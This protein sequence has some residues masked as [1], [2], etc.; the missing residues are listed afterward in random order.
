MPKEENKM[1]LGFKIGD[2]IKSTKYN[3]SPI[4]IERIYNSKAREG[5][6][7]FQSGGVILYSDEVKL[8]EPEEEEFC[9]FWNNSMQPFLAQFNFAEADDGI[10]TYYTKQGLHGSLVDLSDA[11]FCFEYCEPFLGKLPTLYKNIKKEK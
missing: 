1:K 7:S 6:E 9:W 3:I 10:L 4:R 11:L 5:I 2:W 8:W